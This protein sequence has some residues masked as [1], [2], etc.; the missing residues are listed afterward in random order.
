MQYQH[1]K[2]GAIAGTRVLEHLAV[3]GGVAESCVGPAT[4]HE[5]NALGLACVVVVQQQLG[6]LGQERLA[7]LGVPYFVPRAYPLPARAGCRR[8]PP[9]TP[10]EVLP[11]AGDDVGLV[12]VR[13]QVLQ[14][15]LHRQIRELV[16][17]F[18]QRGSLAS[19]IHFFASA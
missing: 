2:P 11:A 9:S 19:A 3:T 1:R 13:A 18:F 15:F 16:Y 4:D 17:G 6:L 8:W 14:H 5:V 12:A 7:V 10:H